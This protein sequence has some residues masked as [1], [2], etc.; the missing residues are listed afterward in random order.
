[1]AQGRKTGGRKAGVPN[2][3]TALIRSR[4]EEDA[5][6]IGLLMQIA[7]GD[8]VDGETPTLDQ[9]AH[10]ARW[11]GA[12][13]CPDARDIFIS[14]DMGDIETPKDAMTAAA[15]VISATA[16]G[17][18]PVGEAKTLLDLIAAF[19]KAYEAHELEERIKALEDAQ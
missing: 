4:I 14:I 17:E 15:R 6:P 10:A 7:K 11:L 13:V 9:R 3:A 8:E 16:S 18:V 1:M 12:K 19:V 2:K 5:D